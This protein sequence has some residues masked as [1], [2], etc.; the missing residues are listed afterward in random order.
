MKTRW[1]RLTLVA[2]ALLLAAVAML[3]GPRR[4]APPDVVATSVSGVQDPAS[5]RDAG[6]APRPEVAPPRGAA[7]ADDRAQEAPAS[8]PAT[9]ESPDL[10]ATGTVQLPAEAQLEAPTSLSAELPYDEAPA[11]TPY[12]SPT[13]S[14]NGAGVPQSQVSEPYDRSP[15]EMPFDV[16]T[17]PVSD[18]AADSQY[19]SP[20]EAPPN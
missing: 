18:P 15:T 10:Y 4:S 11:V 14:Q 20:T 16:S 5:G 7:Q 19:P 8:L 6:P 13:G 2:A 1:M 17:G 9:E 3:V 12:D